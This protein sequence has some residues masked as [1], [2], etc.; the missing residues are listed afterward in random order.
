MEFVSELIDEQ[1]RNL[2]S[3]AVLGL[4]AHVVFVAASNW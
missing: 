2:L 1:H 3:L 4:F